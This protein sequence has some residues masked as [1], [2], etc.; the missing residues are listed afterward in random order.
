MAT[1]L[2][3]QMSLGA[4]TSMTEI[5]PSEV[6]A[7]EIVLG[8]LFHIR[9]I[10]AGEDPYH[11]SSGNYGPIYATI[12]GGCSDQKLAKLMA[13]Q[14]ALKVAAEVTDFDFVAG[15]VTG[16]VPPSIYLRD[17]VQEIQEREISWVYIRD[18]RK[19]GG[20]KEYV[21]GLKMPDGSRT[22]F[23]PEG[24]VGLVVE[25][26]V[27]FANS[28]TNGARV[29]RSN[30]CKCVCNLGVTILDYDN[31]EAERYRGEYGVSQLSVVRMSEVLDA[32]E[33]HG[34]YPNELVEDARWSRCNPLEWMAYY[35]LEKTEHEKKPQLDPDYLLFQQDSEAWAKQHGY[36]RSVV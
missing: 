18:T 31:P 17:W 23:I 36:I 9:D 14:L 22:P 28:T 4:I 3:E 16:G 20:T 5:L 24:S 10:A 13:R 15:L 25:E 26:L 2:V 32:V 19:L 1:R 34:T 29:L 21:T 12:K 30:E 11:Y 33:R 7:D 6:I 8:H 35:G 27:N